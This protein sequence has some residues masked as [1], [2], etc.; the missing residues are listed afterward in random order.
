MSASRALQRL[1]SAG[2]VAMVTAC[3]GAV[4][5]ASDLEPA[6]ALELGREA[7]AA[8]VAAARA[9]ELLDRGDVVA[10]GYLERLRLGLGSP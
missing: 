5:R 3:G 2:A 7:S 8:L 1:L 4:D 6:E 9:P 10:L